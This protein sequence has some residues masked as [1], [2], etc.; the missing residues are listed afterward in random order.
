MMCLLS[1]AGVDP[2]T[3][4]AVTSYVQYWMD[5]RSYKLVLYLSFLGSKVALLVLSAYGSGDRAA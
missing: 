1:I 3:R 5:Y 4:F 2:Y